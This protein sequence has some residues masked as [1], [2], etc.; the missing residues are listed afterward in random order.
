MSVVANRTEQSCP[1][2][3]HLT[4]KKPAGKDCHGMVIR[5]NNL[6]MFLAVKSTGARAGKQSWQTTWLGISGLVQLYL[7]L[8]F[9]QTLEGALTFRSNPESLC[10]PDSAKKPCCA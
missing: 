2:L 9:W 5:R 8:A 3:A 7:A 6:L 10:L 1:A 4:V